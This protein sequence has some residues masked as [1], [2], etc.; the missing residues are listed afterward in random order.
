MATTPTQTRPLQT[1]PLTLDAEL[2][3]L[4][5][6]CKRFAETMT[7]SDDPA[8]RLALCEQLTA[9]LT[10]LRATRNASRP[11]HPES[12]SITGAHPIVSSPFEPDAKQLCAY[13]LALTQALT[14]RTLPTDVEQ[15][16]SALLFELM[17]FLAAKLR[18]S[19]IAGGIIPVGQ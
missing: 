19:R 16:L 11:P 8:L 12:P 14:H 15:T 3:I 1:Q 13:C 2:T 7:K 18:A 4:A 5:D 6:C 9:S 17:G 10:K